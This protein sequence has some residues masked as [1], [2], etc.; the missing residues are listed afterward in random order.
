[1]QQLSLVEKTI[2]VQTKEKQVVKTI[3]GNDLMWSKVNAWL[4]NCKE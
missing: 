2:E 4:D 1:M 3:T